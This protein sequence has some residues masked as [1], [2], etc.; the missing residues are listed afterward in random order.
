M[1][2]TPITVLVGPKEGL[3]ARKKA[4][5]R[6]YEFYMSCSDIPLAEHVKEAVAKKLA[7]EEKII[8]DYIELSCEKALCLE[9]DKGE[10]RKA[11]LYDRRQYEKG[12][13]DAKATVIHCKEC[14]FYTKMRSDLDTGICS[15]ASRH[16]G[17]D[18]FCSEAERRSDANSK[19]I[20]R[21]G[22]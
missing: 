3:E 18:G 12:Y 19:A 4:M 17:D 1:Y 13:A 11:L 9:I 5:E 10:L 8:T 20:P 15:L 16:L 22:K 2:E 14:K 6:F 7:D 21:S